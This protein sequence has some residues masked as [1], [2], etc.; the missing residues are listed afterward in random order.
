MN[1]LKKIFLGL[2]VVVALGL[3]GA[4]NA[5]AQISCTA[6]SVPT[7]VRSQGIAELTGSVVLGCT[8]TGPAAASTITDT[9]QPSAAVI[10]NNPGVPPTISVQGLTGAGAFTIVAGVYSGTA[11]ANACDGAAAG[12]TCV[13]IGAVSGNTVTFPVPAISA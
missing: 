7:L 6:N 10:T 3:V 9:I 11:G 5:A 12:T 2:A 8:S 4:N 13:A 1:Q